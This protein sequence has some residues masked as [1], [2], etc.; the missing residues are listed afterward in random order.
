M[1]FLRR[2]GDKAQPWKTR[3]QPTTTTTPRGKTRSRATSPS[4]W[5]ST[6]RRRTP[7]ST[8]SKRTSSSTRNSP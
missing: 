3:P 2:T 4:S 5:P 1:T 6:S 8:G 7:R